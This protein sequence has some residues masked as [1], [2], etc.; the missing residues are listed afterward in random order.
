MSDKGQKKLLP[1]VDD[2]H[3]YTQAVHSILKDDCKIRI[4]TNFDETKLFAPTLPA[5][6]LI[7]TPR[8]GS[9][10][11]SR[12]SIRKSKKMYG[13]VVNAGGWDGAAGQRASRRGDCDVGVTVVPV[14]ASY[15]EHEP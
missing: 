5:S 13:S 11:G 7:A 10:L 12:R 6:T 1:L 15:Q 3:I 8:S 2:N 9:I 14:A 4:A